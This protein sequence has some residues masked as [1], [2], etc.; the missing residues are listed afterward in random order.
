MILRL[1]TEEELTALQQ[2]L[3]AKLPSRMV[4]STEPVITT[5]TDA[6]IAHLASLVP[7]ATHFKAPDDI[8][9]EINAGNTSRKPH[10]G[11]RATFEHK[12]L[13]R[14]LTQAQIPFQEEFRFE[15]KR[16][17]KADFMIPG[18]GWDVWGSKGYWLVEIVGGLWMKRGGHSQGQA[19]LDDMEKFNHAA[20]LGYR[21]LQFS[22]DQVK[23]GE[24]IG[25]IEQVLA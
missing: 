23:S 3:K 22:P 15:P 4:H 13:S 20:K 5:G 21:V 11:P 2:K 14:Q 12:L 7:L 24:A 16:R 17:W 10:K 9:A 25:F 6:A 18:V 8:L 1:Q 19:Q